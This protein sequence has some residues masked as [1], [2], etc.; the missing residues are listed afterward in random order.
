MARGGLP[1][2]PLSMF[3][4]QGFACKSLVSR[5]E[6]ISGGGRAAL[7]ASADTLSRLTGQSALPS[8]PPPGAGGHSPPPHPAA[9][10]LDAGVEGSCVIGICCFAKWPRVSTSPAVHGNFHFLITCPVFAYPSTISYFKNS[11]TV[12][13]DTLY[14]I[15]TY[16]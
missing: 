10:L 14:F 4:P 16:L 12:F 3:C 2:S 11:S 1:T 6:Y 9:G 5:G 7:P 8:L 15:S 13:A